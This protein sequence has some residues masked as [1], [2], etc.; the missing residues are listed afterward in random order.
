[1][2]KTLD[3]WNAELATC[4]TLEELATVKKAFDLWTIDLQDLDDQIDTLLVKKKNLV[5]E[6]V[7]TN[8]DEITRTYYALLSKLFE[9][10]YMR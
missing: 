1:M 9:L 10:T 3:D 8:M 7:N 5:G 6:G 2:V 4:A